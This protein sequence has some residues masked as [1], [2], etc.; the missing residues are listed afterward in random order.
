MTKQ[1]LIVATL[2]GIFI[3]GIILVVQPVQALS[4]DAPDWIAI[5]STLQTFVEIKEFALFNLDD[6]GLV[7]VLANDPRGG[8]VEPEFLK[9]VQTM[10]RKPDLKLADIGF[11]DATQARYAY[12]RKVKELYD[13]A[14][15]SG[16]VIIPT[17]PPYDPSDNPIS[18]DI[19]GTDKDLS[20]K[21]RPDP[22]IVPEVRELEQETGLAAGL[23]ISANEIS[24]PMGFKIM[25]IQVKDDL[26]YAKVD[27]DYGLCEDIF[28]K[29]DG[30]WYLIGH[31]IIEWHGG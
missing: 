30:R 10:A 11:L 28:I 31:K 27:W 16:E 20:L 19:Q 29:K 5:E 18:I 3:F 14:I 17:P 4:S 22:R 9:L 21:V 1:I 7:D 26:A 24:L 13:H 8:L 2:L 12:D 25:S 23:P 15:A 6:T